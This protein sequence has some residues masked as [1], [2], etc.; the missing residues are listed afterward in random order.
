MHLITVDFTTCE[1]SLVVCRRVRSRLVKD[2]RQVNRI[3]PKATVELHFTA[4]TVH[5]TYAHNREL[6]LWD[7]YDSPRR[8][9]ARAGDVFVEASGNQPLKVTFVMRDA[10]QWFHRVERNVRALRAAFKWFCE[11][12]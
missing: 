10:F 4:P 1:V 3:V 12:L 8:V 11:S 9:Y 2:Y 5:H 6:V 7:S